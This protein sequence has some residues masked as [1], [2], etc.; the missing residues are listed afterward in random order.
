[1]YNILVRLHSSWKFEAESFYAGPII[2][3]A[4]PVICMREG[5]NAWPAMLPT[6]DPIGFEGSNEGK[7]CTGL[8]IF[9]SNLRHWMGMTYLLA[10]A[11]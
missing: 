3:K 8:A 1:M 9:F 2:P 6:V 10:T 4:C 5:P 7:T 11:A